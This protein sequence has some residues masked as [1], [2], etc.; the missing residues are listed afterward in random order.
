MKYII[1]IISG[2]L[3]LISG[4]YLC[5]DFCFAKPVENEIISENNLIEIEQIIQRLNPTQFRSEINNEN[6]IL[7]DIRTPEEYNEGHIEGAINI[8]YYSH[9]FSNQI[10]QL[11]KDKT[12]YIYCR[13][14]SRSG[15]AL[16][17]FRNLNFNEVYD[18]RNGI[19]SWVN[20][21]FEI[22]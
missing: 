10:S 7:I 18:L 2:L 17:V 22:H 14:G 3:L 4:T 19:N 13:R 1:I 6:I 21:G 8:N 20:Q 5:L 11:D 9:D 15:N 12:Y 16:E